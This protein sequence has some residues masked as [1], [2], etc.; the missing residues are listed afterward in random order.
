MAGRSDLR[1]ILGTRKCWRSLSTSDWASTTRK[2]RSLRR[3][4]T[5][6][7]KSR[8][9]SELRYE[10][11]HCRCRFAPAVMIT[12]SDCFDFSGQQQPRRRR[13]ELECRNCRGGAAD[14]VQDP[15]HRGHRGRQKTARE[16]AEA[17]EGVLGI[18][19]LV[20]DVMLCISASSSTN[21]S[22][23]GFERQPQEISARITRNIDESGFKIKCTRNRQ[24]PC[25][26]RT[27]PVCRQTTNRSDQAIRQI[28]SEAQTTLQLT[29]SSKSNAG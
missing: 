9:T 4:K 3:R 15:Q 11:S 13:F 27:R 16:R 28:S 12:T 5:S 6:C 22:C 1:A 14:R 29:A 20:R 26:P 17:R 23:F 18:N 2:I 8:S 10:A 24:P 25:Q 7:I 19:R 21:F